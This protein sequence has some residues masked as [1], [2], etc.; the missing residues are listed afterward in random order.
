MLA[1]GRCAGESKN[2]RADDR[3]NPE[4]GQ[5]PRPQRF[6]KPV[7]RL[8]CIGDELVNGLLGEKLAG[9]DGLL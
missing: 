9:Q 8:F 5:R 7:L 6:L 1:G 4:G 3:P 2:A